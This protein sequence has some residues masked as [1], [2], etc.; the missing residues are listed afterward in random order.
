MFVSVIISTKNEE[1][2]VENCLQSVLAQNFPREKMEII[3]VDNSSSDNTQSIARRY[4]DK[5]YDIGE[6]VDLSK[7]K[8]YRGAQLNFGVD[9]ARGEI[10]FFPDADMTFQADLFSEAAEMFKKCDALYVPEIVRGSGFLGKLRDFER[11]FYNETCIDGVRFV[12]KKIYHQVGGFDVKNILFGPDDWDFTKMLKK[13]G[14]T[15]DITQKNIFHHEEGMTWRSYLLK[16]GK[17]IPTLE[18]YV[19]KWGKND[20]DIKK[21]FS[22]GYRFFGVFLEKGKWKKIVRHPFLTAGMFAS[23]FMVGLIYLVKK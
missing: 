13:I 19:S 8:N 22:F 23:R 10:I 11:S 5:V 17:Y 2:N 18:M 9:N 7:V 4:A 16:K 6:N 21:Q 12:R 14:A 3:V 15:L 20:P 1:K